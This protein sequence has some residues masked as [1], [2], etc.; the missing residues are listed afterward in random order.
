MFE[1]LTL[2]EAERQSSGGSGQRRNKAVEGQGSGGAGQ[3]RETNCRIAGFGANSLKQCILCCNH[4][5]ASPVL[6]GRQGGAS[7][8]HGRIRQKK[9][10]LSHN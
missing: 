1:S 4:R 2:P 9:Q 6:T 7:C 3:W 5:L 10:L 8:L